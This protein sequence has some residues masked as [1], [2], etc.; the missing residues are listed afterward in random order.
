VAA[1][2]LE[3]A[4]LAALLTA[5]DALERTLEAEAEALDAM[6]EATA[7]ME[8]AAELADP[9]R[10]VVVLEDMLVPE[11]EAAAVE[12]QVAEGRFV[13]PT[14]LQIPLAN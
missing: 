1:A 3:L 9:F 12:A 8:L 4:D 7:D 2:A 11:L 10:D 14:G 6:D 5:A 13:T